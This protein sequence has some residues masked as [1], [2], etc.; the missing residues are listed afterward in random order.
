MTDG[1]RP[2]ALSRMA[3]NYAENA[4]SQRAAFARTYDAV[5]A[6]VEAFDD[7]PTLRVVDLGA[8]D[9]VNSLRAG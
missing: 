7:E 3:D 1:P 6:A 9:G 8:A 5:L 4:R 2:S